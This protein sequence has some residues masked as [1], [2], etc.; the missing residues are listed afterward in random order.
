VRLSPSANAELSKWGASG[1]GDAGRS[2]VLIKLRKAL[3]IAI[4]VLL[5][6]GTSGGAS[7]L[8]ISSLSGVVSTTTY[9]LSLGDLNLSG[10][11]YGSG[12]FRYYT[13][14]V[15]GY[16]V[17]DYPVRTAPVPEPSAALVFGLGLFAASRFARR[18]S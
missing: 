10:W 1:A 14:Y 11:S 8:T 6:L 13:S 16:Q 9:Q 3:T 18:K 17:R 5:V 7:A 15:S 2:A 4:A 12:D